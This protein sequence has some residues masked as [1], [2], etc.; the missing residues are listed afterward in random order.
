VQKYLK[1]KLSIFVVIIFIL[2]TF[3]GSFQ[4]GIKKAF[5]A[6]QG[7]TVH[8]YKPSGWSKANIYY[9]G[10]NFTGP[11]WPGSAMTQEGGNWYSYTIFNHDSVRVLFNDGNGNQIP[12]PG[13]PGFLVSGESWYKDG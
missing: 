6:D 10:D 11:A 7:I 1:R 3:I 13:Q 8:F 5:A 12:G 4:Q 9:Y 2:A